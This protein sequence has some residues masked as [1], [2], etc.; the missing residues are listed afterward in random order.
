MTRPYVLLSVAT[1]VDGYLDDTGPERLLLSNDADFD[2]VDQVRAES[3]AILVGAATV[4]TDNPRLIVKSEARQ[5]ARVAAGR[6][7]HPLKVT[8]TATGD[9]DPAAKFWHHGTEDHR[10]VVYTT[11]AGHEKTAQLLDGLADV[12]DLGPAID[13]GALLD[14]LGG[15]GVRRLMVEAAGT[16]IPPSSPTGSRTN[17]S[18]RS[19]RLWSGKR[20]LHGSC[21]R[22][23][24][25]ADH[26]V[27][28]A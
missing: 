9:L 7:H 3:D 8:V 17:S 28:C 2:R 16:S 13:F 14:D 5:A 23:R 15:R 26:T 10:P 22:P 25:P 24:S 21:T 1:S 4:R 20:T 6:S 27:A 12:V 11:S 18:S 19:G